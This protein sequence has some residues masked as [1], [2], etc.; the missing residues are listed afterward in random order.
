MPYATHSEM[1][2]I[3]KQQNMVKIITLFSPLYSIHT[4][5][6]KIIYIP[7]MFFIRH[8]SNTTTIRVFQKYFTTTTMETTEDWPMAHEYAIWNATMA[9]LQFWAEDLD[10]VSLGIASECIYTTFF[11]TN[12]SHTL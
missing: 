7:D 1:R 9:S 2:R 4:D 5:A 3:F 6:F 11:W 8:T 10:P 12:S